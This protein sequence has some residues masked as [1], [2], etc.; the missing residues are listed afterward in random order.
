MARIN[1]RQASN[2]TIYVTKQVDT[3]IVLLGSPESD[4][5]LDALQYLL[6]YAGIHFNNLKYLQ[7]CGLMPKLLNLLQKNICIL[8]LS[9]RLLELL[10]T[11]EEVVLELDQDVY[12]TKILKISDMY[13]SHH[14]ITVR[15][16]CASIISTLTRSYKITCLI[17]NVKL[18]KHILDTIKKTNDANLLRWSLGLLSKLLNT[19][20]ASNILTKIRD[21]NVFVLVNLLDSLGDN[22][23]QLS[24]K[25]IR[26]LTS[27]CLDAF[28]KMF[29]KAKLVEIM[30]NVIM[31][32]TRKKYHEISFGIISDCMKSEETSS[33]FIKTFEFLNFCQWVKK[34]E[35]EYHLPCILIFEQLT[36]APSRRQILFDLS[37]EDSILSFLRNSEKRVL[38]KTCEAISNMMTHKYCC[39]EMLRPQVLKDLFHILVKKYNFKNEAVL[40]IILD[41]SRRNLDTIDMI[42]NTGAHKVFLEYCKKDIGFISEENFLGILE[43]LYKM[44]TIS[45]FQQGLVSTS[46]FE[47]L[48]HLFRTAPPNTAI[49]ICEIMINFVSCPEFRRTFLSLNGSQIFFEKLQT[50]K[51][52]KLLKIALFFIHSNLAYENM[53]TDFLHNNIVGVL[54]EFPEIF[55]LQ[56]PI[57]GKILK[58]VYNCHLPLKFYETNKLDVTDKLENKFYLIDGQWK[59]DFPFHENLEGLPLSTTYTIYVVDYSFEVKYDDESSGMSNISPREISSERALSTLT[60]ISSSMSSYYRRNLF[61]I[62][63]GKLCP[64]PFLPSHIYNLNKHLMQINKSEDKVRILA[65]YVDAIFR[66]PTEGYSKLEKIHNFKLHVEMLKYKLGSN[67]IPIGF[68]RQGRHCERALLFKAMADKCRIPTTLTRSK[69]NL[70]WNEIISSDPE[71]NSN[72][73]KW[74]VVDLVNN[75]GDLLVV[76]SRKANHYCNLNT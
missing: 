21:F 69:G 56:M 41:F 40:K 47:Q 73:M 55:K 6:E 67:L 11:I 16:L 38:D 2:T 31:D 18:I 19:E 60:K 12:N 15:Q 48:L 72:S 53:V 46:F 7:R 71:P 1:R 17:L 4:V 24:F 54:E 63:Y 62:N 33:Y 68:L 52:V 30:L 36:R 28:Q 42:Y 37:V 9:L 74:Y 59:D 13:V 22:V 75:I 57:S 27:F 3:S 35:P 50:S 29:R 39:E 32:D 43:I 34:C 58:L 49:R 20:V 23:A 45:S 10:L 66:K 25:I 8:R 51:D 44:S 65:K 64:D 61:Q 76:G 70:Y 14:D 26:K 5:A